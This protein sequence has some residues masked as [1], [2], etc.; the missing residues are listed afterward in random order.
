MY[1]SSL[2]LSPYQ[3]PP[4]SSFLT[5]T[6]HWSECHQV[7]S[8]CSTFASLT[9]IKSYAEQLTRGL[10]STKVDWQDTLRLWAAR[11]E[12]LLP[13]PR[14]RAE[15]N[16]LRRDGGRARRTRSQRLLII[17]SCV[18]RRSNPLFYTL[19]N[20]TQTDNVVCQLVGIAN[21]LFCAKN[22]EMIYL[23]E[24]FCDWGN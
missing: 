12:G 18:R 3:T 24:L 8:P 20:S 21:C 11:W 7:I 4:P 19:T 14:L 2:L 13:G 1:L 22:I 23:T 15:V 5:V 9:F 10:R 6:S 16:I 17:L